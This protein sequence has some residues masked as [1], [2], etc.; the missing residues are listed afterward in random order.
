MLTE[1]CR[2]LAKAIARDGEGATCLFEVTVSGAVNDAGAHQVARTIAGSALVKSA[3]FGH[4]PNWGRIAAAAGRAGVS[5]DQN[6]LRI[7]LGDSL[8]MEHGQPLPF[9]RAAAS[10]YIKTATQGE[11][12]KPTQSR[13]RSALVMAPAAARPGAAT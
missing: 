1:V 10:A 6:D 8:L 11:Y 9:D 7:Q 3:I 12:L 5:F 2:H 13:F 4:D